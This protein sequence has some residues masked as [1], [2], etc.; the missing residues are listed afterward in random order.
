MGCIGEQNAQKD[1]E[2]ACIVYKFEATFKQ[3]KGKIMFRRCSTMKIVT[4]MMFGVLAVLMLASIAGMVEVSGAI[5][6]L[7]Q[8]GDRTWEY[9]REITIQENSGETLRD[10]QVLVALGGDG[11][12]G[13][14]QGDAQ[15]DGDDMSERAKIWVRMP[16]ILASGGAKPFMIKSENV[17]RE[18]I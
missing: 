14:A 15:A 3:S 7:P 10:Y 2:S 13:D 9:C 16:P 17:W 18:T 11:F 12:P 5:T 1:I 4:K 6:D 8:S